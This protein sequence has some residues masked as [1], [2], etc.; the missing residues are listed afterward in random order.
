VLR[1]A[2]GERPAET[3]EPRADDEV[4]AAAGKF[5]HRAEQP[6][7]AK[8]ADVELLV[9]STLANLAIIIIIII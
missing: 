7:A 3:G 5:Q 9:V 8:R 6:E 1:A 4:Q 2:A